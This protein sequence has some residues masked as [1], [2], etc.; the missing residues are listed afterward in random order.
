MN[1]QLIIDKIITRALSENRKK[2]QG[3]YYEEHHIIPRCMGGE[4]GPTVFL[5]GKEH[6]LIHFL[7]YRLY[8]ENKSLEYA[9][10]QMCIDPNS[11]ERGYK[12]SGRTY[13]EARIKFCKD[14]SQ[15]IKE[16]K[17]RGNKISQTNKNFSKEKREA[18]NQ[19][20]RIWN[21][22]PIPQFDLQ[23]NFIK[24]WPSQ[25]EIY[26]VLGIIIQHNLK[27]YQFQAGGFKWKYKNQPTPEFKPK[28]IPKRVLQ[29][30]PQTN[31]IIKIW[32]YPM[33]IQKELNWQIDGVLR[34][35]NKKTISHNFLW[36][37]EE[38][39]NKQLKVA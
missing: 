36:F 11:K 5:A 32:D 9:F 20:L 28:Y 31:Q 19:K 29:I 22:I 13:E 37:Y 25:L 12:V 15:T 30:D 27:G 6:F 38:D 3:T 16:N 23:G 35:K 1:Y 18:I 39:Y 26:N 17:E 4:K 24:E 21:S 10:W 14:I 33:Q 34:K 2:G 8:P 7:F